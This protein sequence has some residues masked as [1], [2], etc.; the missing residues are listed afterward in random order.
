MS[1][2]PQVERA[3]C[4][5]EAD[6]AA[7]CVLRPYEELAHADMGC[8][9]ES[10]GRVRCCR[11]HG[12]AERATAR[13]K[14]AFSQLPFLRDCRERLGHPNREMTPPQLARA[15]ALA[16]A[17]VRLQPAVAAAF[18]ALRAEHLEGRTA[19]GVHR[20]ETDKLLE[21]EQ[22]PLDTFFEAIDGIVEAKGADAEVVIYL[23]TDSAAA[24]AAFK[25]RYGGAVVYRQQALRSHGTQAVH[26]DVDSKAESGRDKVMD[27]VLD[28]LM[29]GACQHLVRTGSGVSMAAQAFSQPTQQVVYLHGGHC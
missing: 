29:L 2:D 23:A 10:G 26:L 20:R 11:I 28:A 5:E 1:D 12:D 3:T 17:H 13:D 18:E 19:I 4:S 22:V 16:A 6:P 21:C 7:A 14:L 15:R 9:L 8:S 25:Q 27:V 24:V